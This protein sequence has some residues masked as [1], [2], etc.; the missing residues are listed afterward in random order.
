MADSEGNRGECERI[1]KRFDSNGDGKISISELE[2][3]LHA[4]GCSSPEEVVRRMSEIDK[5]GNGFISLDELCDFQRANPDLMKEDGKGFAR[6]LGM[7]ETGEPTL[8]D[9]LVSI[10]RS[11][12][13]RLVSFRRP[14]RRRAVEEVKREKE[15]ADS[16]GP[17]MCCR[18]SRNKVDDGASLSSMKLYD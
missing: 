13:R 17:L 6:D 4:L 10:H 11:S 9:E 18:C 7:S 16:D 12:P 1:F 15:G 3:A 2:S 8:S 14:K 5:D